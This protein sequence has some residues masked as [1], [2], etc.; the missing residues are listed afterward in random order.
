MSPIAPV[1]GI[2]TWS[3][4]P[5]PR[6]MANPRERERN[7]EGRVV[8][9]TSHPNPVDCWVLCKGKEYFHLFGNIQGNQKHKLQYTKVDSSSRVTQDEDSSPPVTT[10]SWETGPP[11]MAATERLLACPRERSLRLLHSARSPAPTTGLLHVP[12]HGVGQEVTLQPSSM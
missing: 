7:S 2:W 4:G 12:M 11:N 9:A 8:I 5:R 6:P 3:P 1:S 10:G